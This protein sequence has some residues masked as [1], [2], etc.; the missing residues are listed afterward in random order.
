MTDTGTQLL[1][2]LSVTGSTGLLHYPRYNSNVAASLNQAIRR[3][4][5]DNGIKVIAPGETARVGQVVI[6][7]A[8]VFE[9]ALDRFPTIECERLFVIQRTGDEAS[10]DPAAIAYDD[11]RV[12]KHL[13]EFFGVE[14]EWV[15]NLVDV[16]E[17]AS[18]S[19]ESEAR[20]PERVAAGQT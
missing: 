16:L 13:V 7:D 4:A 20:A 5:W 2:Q 12:R 3:F 8:S 14:G 9:H 10:R 11:G 1:Q 6:S 17:R 15:P 18:K 19:V